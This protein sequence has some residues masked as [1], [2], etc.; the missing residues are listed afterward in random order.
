[1]AQDN[2]SDDQKSRSVAQ[3]LRE[4]FDM[5]VKVQEDIGSAEKGTEGIR[6]AG[7]KIPRKKIKPRSR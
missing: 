3:W 7:G 5:E 1:M 6:E 2:N 4:K